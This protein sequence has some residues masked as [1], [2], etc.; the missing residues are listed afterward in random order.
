MS[1]TG[2][3]TP[4]WRVMC[5]VLFSSALLSVDVFAQTKATLSGVVKDEVTGELLIGASV[6]IQKTPQ[7]AVT[8]ARG[9]YKIA[10]IAPGKYTVQASYIGYQNQTADILLGDG[11]DLILNISLKV[12]V[13]TSDEIV[14]MGQ[15]QGQSRALNNQLNSNK[16]VNIID[17][18]R[19]G[20]FP[21]QN[22]AEA[23]ARVPGVALQRDGGEG[24]KVI[25]RGL[26]PNLSSV[27]VNG[28]RVPGTANGLDGGRFTDQGRAASLSFIP[29][30]MVKTIEVFKAL[31]P[32][33][34]AD[35]IGGTVN[36]TTRN[37]KE[38]LRLNVV[39]RQ[40]YH[41]QDGDPGM[42]Q[43]NGFISNRILKNRVGVVFN[44]SYQLANRSSEGFDVGY[45]LS[46]STLPIESMEI[47]DR[48]ETRKRLGLSGAFDIDLGGGSEL[49]FR[50]NYGQTK[51]E[52]F[53]R[54]EEYFT[55]RASN[56]FALTRDIR[57]RNLTTSLLNLAVTGKHVFG[58]PELDWSITYSSS[59]ADQPGDFFYRFRQTA[60][61]A[62]TIPRDVA[63]DSIQQYAFDTTRF[64][65]GPG[66]ARG[67]DFGRMLFL[68]S[69]RQEFRSSDADW[70]GRLN[71]KL[72]LSL[73]STV[74]GYVRLGGMYRT[75]T[76]VNE[77]RQFN[78]PQARVD[79]LARAFGLVAPNGRLTFRQFAD[80]TFRDE[81]FFQDRFRFESSFNSAALQDFYN[82]V[83]ANLLIRQFQLELNNYT[84]REDVGASYLM[85]E[86]NIGENLMLLG[87]ARYEYTSVNNIGKVGLPEGSDVRNFRD[88][89]TTASYGEWFPMAHARYRFTPRTEI[90]FA[91][92]RT[93]S[94]PNYYDLIP[95]EEVRQFDIRQG[96][97]A[98]QP[99]TAWNFDVMFSHYLGTVGVI[100]VGMFHKRISNYIY[101]TITPE[102][103]I[104]PTTGNLRLYQLLRPTNAS[105]GVISGVEVDLQAG[106]PKPFSNFR[107]YANY[108]FL[109]AF[110]D[111]PVSRVTRGRVNAGGDT[112]ITGSPNDPVLSVEPSTRRVQ[113]P[114]QTRH[115]G[116]VA[117]G[118]ERAGLSMRI[119]ANYQ[120]RNIFAVGTDLTTD[121]T[122]WVAPFTRVDFTASYQPRFLQ[123]GKFYLDLINITNQR[124]ERYIGERVRTDDQRLFGMWGN[125]GFGL[126][127]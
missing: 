99:A 2:R 85:T 63:I 74:N 66:G 40:G 95:Y 54:L 57:E 38:G 52:G 29:P 32:D 76:R 108:T 58:K 26:D 33:M 1:L 9:R 60:A 71:F 28:E 84:A 17:A 111:I 87:G 46:D 104:D 49:V 73:S 89:S 78:L 53:A 37:A 64:G 113:L 18:E 62:N 11:Q 51:R 79:S 101:T 59:D 12:Q 126:S 8:D 117:L 118:F 19:I 20:E 35:A 93:L 86:L 107:V 43:Y 21:D 42:Y 127:F 14:V 80:S 83:P 13:V 92:T 116:N 98:L 25:I 56:P 75:K 121:Q 48:I 120:D 24:Q 67:R 114:G 109:D 70:V 10:G 91:T 3:V 23:V 5:V 30:D 123:R 6:R 122:V 65:A 102:Q 15:L 81:G 36:L 68:E 125:L 90:R 82:R 31:T 16:I 105:I 72:P 61:L 110:T 97:P 69:W 34:D 103:R 96:N 100:S 39:G 44:A 41:F 124:E 115:L 119:S 88:S 4:L 27:T 22:A 112:V 77:V 47:E 50:A 55:S 45:V 7:G 106:L 94:R